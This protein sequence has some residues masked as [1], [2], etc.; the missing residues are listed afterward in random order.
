[1]YI[2]T[3]L[4][5]NL[6]GIK[7]GN[8]AKIYVSTSD[9]R[10]ILLGSFANFSWNLKPVGWVKL[11]SCWVELGNRWVELGNRWVELGSRW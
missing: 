11:G 9:N 7:T 5:L 6:Y 4:C 2:F 3:F 8:S 10:L 1:M